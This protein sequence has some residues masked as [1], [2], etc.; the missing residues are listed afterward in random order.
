M[1]RH[2]RWSLSRFLVGCKQVHNRTQQQNGPRRWILKKSAFGVHFRTLMN[3]LCHFAGALGESWI[4]LGAPCSFLVAS[5]P[6]DPTRETQVSFKTIPRQARGGPKESQEFLQ[7]AKGRVWALSWGTPLT[8]CY[9][10]AP[11]VDKRHPGKPQSLTTS[12]DG[13]K[14]SPKEV[15]RTPRE[16]KKV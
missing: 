3:L 1:F 13:A 15:K 5:W 4:Y 11:R 14:Q 10:L 9:F 2:L 7:T 12:Q 6:Q 8:S 16:L